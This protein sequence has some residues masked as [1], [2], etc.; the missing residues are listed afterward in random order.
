MFAAQIEEER[1]EGQAT[2]LDE[3]RPISG[4]AS[5]IAFRSS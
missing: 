5:C 1:I 3:M 2:C 4:P